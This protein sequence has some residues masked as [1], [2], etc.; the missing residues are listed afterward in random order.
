[1]KLIVALLKIDIQKNKKTGS[2]AYCQTHDV[3]KGKT[4]VPPQVT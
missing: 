1:M 2:H 4:F 3:D